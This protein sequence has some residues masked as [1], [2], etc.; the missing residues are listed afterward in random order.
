MSSKLVK[1]PEL[2]EKFVGQKRCVCCNLKRAKITT[3]VHILLYSTYGIK[4]VISVDKVLF[5]FARKR[6]N[7]EKPLLEKS[8]D[9]ISLKI[10]FFFLFL[11]WTKKVYNYFHWQ[12][13]SLK[14]IVFIERQPSGAN[15]LDQRKPREPP[16]IISSFLQF[17]GGRR[18]VSTYVGGCYNPFFT[19]CKP[20]SLRTPVIFFP[21]ATD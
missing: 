7:E 16:R 20:Q 11:L 1:M 6:R 8:H 14:I 3:Y 2:Q 18:R 10:Q 13:S 12:F 15:F 17:R 5:H 9:F 21:L 19:R 4:Q